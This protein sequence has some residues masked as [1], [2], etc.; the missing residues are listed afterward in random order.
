MKRILL[1]LMI[2]LTVVAALPFTAAGPYEGPSSLGD[3]LG[4]VFSEIANFFSMGWLE[5]ESTRQG[6]LRFLLFITVFS[7]L[8]SAGIP[9][10][11]QIGP[12][13]FAQRNAGIFSGVIATVTII[14]TPMN[15]L[16]GIFS[17]YTAVILFILTIIPVGA[18]YYLIYPVAGNAISGQWALRIMRIIGLLLIWFILAEVGNYAASIQASSSSSGLRTIALAALPTAFFGGEE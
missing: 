6:F 7:V 16:I 10:F 9:V 14:F 8:Y 5:D 12:D 15:L 2:I 1:G 18:V 17:S 11:K 3:M 13:K 4:T